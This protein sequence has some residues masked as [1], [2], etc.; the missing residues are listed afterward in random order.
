[1]P[2]TSEQFTA[3]IK[4]VYAERSRGSEKV[5]DIKYFCFGMGFSRRQTRD[6]FP[7]SGTLGKA[8]GAVVSVMLNTSPSQ[9]Q[10]SLVSLKVFRPLV[11]ECLK[12]EELTL[13]R[14]CRYNWLSLAE[15]TAK[16]KQNAVRHIIRPA[17]IFFIP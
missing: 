2:E 6:V 12:A 16:H 15:Y 8:L 5:L 3:L 11:A 13:C 4:V 14:V 9:S 1:M 17:I 7:V 10:P